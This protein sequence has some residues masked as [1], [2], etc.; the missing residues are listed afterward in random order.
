MRNFIEQM[1]Y[2]GDYGATRKSKCHVLMNGILYV[3]MGQ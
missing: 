1:M 3:R 2:F